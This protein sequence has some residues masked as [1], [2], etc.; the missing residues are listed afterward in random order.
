MENVRGRVG[1]E[2]YLNNELE[3]ENKKNIKD[4]KLFNTISLEVYST[5]NLCHERSR[6]SFSFFF[7]QDF[8]LSGEAN[9]LLK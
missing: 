1:S 7:L 5:G 2:N 9:E 4:N 8:P 3:H 6:K